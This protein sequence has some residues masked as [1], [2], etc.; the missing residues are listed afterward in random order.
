VFN[1]AFSRGIVVSFVTAVVATSAVAAPLT[2][3]ATGSY[4]TSETSRQEISFGVTQKGSG[5]EIKN[6]GVYC[7]DGSEVVA[8]HSMSV[9]KS[10]KFSYSGKAA[11]ETRG[12][13][14]GTATLTVAGKFVTATRAKGT[15]RF[16]AKPG[17]T[18]CPGR[19]FTATK[20]Q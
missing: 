5:R 16:T 14:S 6:F 19:S 7:S 11:R 8:A 18:G 13:P 2:S 3:P 9:A 12:A 15:A 1:R 17:L 10:G 4:T 20:I